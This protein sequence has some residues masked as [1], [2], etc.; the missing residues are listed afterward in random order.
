M[1]DTPKYHSGM[2]GFNDVCVRAGRCSLLPV[3]NN[4]GAICNSWKLDPTTLR[5]PLKG[6]LPFDKVVFVRSMC[7][8]THGLVKVC[9]RLVWLRFVIPNPLGPVWAADGATA[10]RVGAAVLEG[11]GV[12]HAGTQQTGVTHLASVPQHRILFFQPLLSLLRL[13][14][15]FYLTVFLPPHT[16]PDFFFPTACSHTPPPHL[17]F[18]RSLHVSCPPCVI[19]LSLCPLSSRQPFASLF[20]LSS[21][22]LF[23]HLSFQ[24]HLFWFLCVVTP[25]LSCCSSSTATIRKTICEEKNSNCVS[26]TLECTWRSF[27]SRFLQFQL[28]PAPQIKFELTSSCL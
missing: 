28:S 21:I 1:I 9:M 17:P 13:F 23:H 18:S 14:P 7:A 25:P 8:Y 12:Q 16:L 15:L 11:D 20:L 6:M 10:L 3:V 4:S 22:C 2:C 27:S 5:F 26:W 24:F 19:P